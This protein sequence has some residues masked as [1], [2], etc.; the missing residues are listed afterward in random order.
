M[1]TTASTAAAAPSRAVLSPH[2]VAIMALFAASLGFRLNGATPDVSWL[3]AMCERMLDGERGWIDIFETTPPIPT[4]LYM[5]GVLAARALG[6]SSEI[7]V[8]ASAYLAVFLSLFAMDRLLP[9]SLAGL[10]PSRLILTLPAAFF[11]FILAH[12]AFAQREYFAAA[13]VLPMFAAFVARAESGVWPP[14]SLRLVAGVL[15][16]LSFAI[17]PPLFALPFIALAGAELLRT[18]SLS[19]LFPSMLPLAALVGVA[20]TA[21]SLLVFPAYLDGVTTLMRDVYVP[22]RAQLKL[23][24]LRGAFCGTTLALA[25]ALVFQRG[26]PTP[27]AAIYAYAIAAAFFAIYWLQGKFFAYH[28]LPAALFAVLALAI[29][30]A[31]RLAALQRAGKRDH[32]EVA[33]FAALILAVSGFILHGFNDAKRRLDNLPW[34]EGLS[35]PTAMAISP[36]ISTGFPLAEHVDAVW[37]DRI[38]SQWVVNYASIMLNRDDTPAADRARYQRYYDSELARTRALI[39][40][41]KPELI[42]QGSMPGVEWLTEA[43]LAGDPQLLDGYAVIGEQKYIRILRRRDLIEASGRE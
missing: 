15:A 36:F 19:F 34:A 21:A 17:K 24:Y 28:L 27:P 20:L 43:L 9:A 2:Y 32:G 23:L 29:A 25:A 39:R 22:I 8:F 4:L 10:G 16:G 30:S 18:R 40:D 38:H 35:R 7:T 41:R 12:D 5:P 33:L 6:V 13:F 26:R 14:L 37:I 11:L 3:T 1:T 42:F 31:P